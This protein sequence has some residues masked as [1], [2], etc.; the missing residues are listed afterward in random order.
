MPS[1]QPSVDR[2]S[3][4]FAT[5]EKSVSSDTSVRVNLFVPDT[6]PTSRMDKV[7][8][9][10]ITDEEDSEDYSASV[11]AIMQ[12]RASTRKSRKKGRRTSSPFSHDD[13]SHSARRRSSVYTTSSG[14]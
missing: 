9:P 2:L 10:T 11:T 8:F 13:G 6:P 5:E 7:R 14:E 1:P 4:T 12:R 3:V